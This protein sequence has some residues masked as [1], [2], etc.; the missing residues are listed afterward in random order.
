MHTKRKA[1][2]QDFEKRERLG[3]DPAKEHEYLEVLNSVDWSADLFEEN[4][5]HG[6][7]NALGEVIVPARYEDFATLTDEEIA[8]GDPIATKKDGKWGILK[9]GLEEEWLIEPQFDY[10]GYPSRYLSV[11]LGDKWGIYDL[12]TGEYKVPV[13]CD[14]VESHPGMVFVNGIGIYTSEGKT[15][16][17]RYDGTITGAIFDEFDMDVDEPVKVKLAG[18]W[19]FINDSG[20]FTTDE[21]EAC[22]FYST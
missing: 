19:G 21:D 18:Q 15:G 4:G 1:T 12:E 9:A 5:K 17:I 7:K 2:I 8:M 16:F 22:F 6:I 3:N 10:V 11:R 20:Q 13:I 14:Q